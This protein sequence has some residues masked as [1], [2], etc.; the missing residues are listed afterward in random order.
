M[1]R[2]I[3]LFLL[4]LYPPTWSHAQRIAA[5][6]LLPAILIIGGAVIFSNTIPALT[7][8]MVCVTGFLVLGIMMLFFGLLV[9]NAVL[10][11]RRNLKDA[12]IKKRLCVDCGYDLRGNESGICPECG[13]S[14][15]LARK[16]NET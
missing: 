8:F 12:R 5:L 9:R 15:A 6:F 4:H 7:D 1:K 14:V 16:W 13:R 3:T 11:H 10:E 2:W